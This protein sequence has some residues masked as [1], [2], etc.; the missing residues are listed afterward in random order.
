MYCFVCTGNIQKTKTQLSCQSR[1]L[2]RRCNCQTNSKA[3]KQHSLYNFKKESRD[4]APETMSPP[5]SHSLPNN[6][7]QTCIHL[8]ENSNDTIESNDGD[9][10]MSIVCSMPSKHWQ[11]VGNITSPGWLFDKSIIEDSKSQCKAFVS[12]QCTSRTGDLMRMHV[13]IPKFSVIV[14]MLRIIH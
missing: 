14:E 3:K 12:Y 2:S 11:L 10:N 5:L 13:T 1:E 9:N 8:S 7:N 4:V 6:C